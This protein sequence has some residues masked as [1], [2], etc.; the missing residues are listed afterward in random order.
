[1]EI[2]GNHV[3]FVFG[4]FCLQM[5]EDIRTACSVSPIFSTSH[6]APGERTMRATK[7]E[8]PVSS[9]CSRSP[10]SIGIT[11]I[12]KILWGGVKDE[13]GGWG[14]GGGK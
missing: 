3:L 9:G 10:C 11:L 6:R 13:R 4:G 14:G 7:R 12:K 8:E 2:S 1:M 5:R